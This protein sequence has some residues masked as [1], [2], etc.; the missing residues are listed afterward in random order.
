MHHPI[1]SQ[2]I[3]RQDFD[4]IYEFLTSSVFGYDQLLLGICS[5]SLSAR[6]FGGIGDVPGKKVVGPVA[7]GS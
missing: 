4:T 6:Q 2:D 1:R 7:D 5:E 3:C